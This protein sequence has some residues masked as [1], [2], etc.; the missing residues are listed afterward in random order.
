MKRIYE[1]IIFGFLLFTF[2]NSSQAGINPTFNMTAKNIHRYPGPNGQDS[3]ITFEIYLQQTNQGQPGVYDFEYCCGQFTLRYNKLIH[4]PGGN[5]VFGIIPDSCE[6]P[7]NLRPPSFQVD[8]VNGYLKASGNLPQSLT[9]FFISGTFPGTKILTFKA[10]TNNRSFNMVPLNLQYKLGPS[11]NTFVASFLPYPDSVDSQLF[12][13]QFAVALYDTLVNHYS[14]EDSS[15]GGA[16]SLFIPPEYSSTSM[17]YINFAWQSI[18]AVSYKLQI[19]TDF[20]FNN[21]VFSDSSLQF[22]NTTVSSL[23]P[24]NTY[25]WRVSAKNGSGYFANSYVSSFNVTADQVSL[26]DPAD[27]Q[28][29]VQVPVTFTWHKAGP[30]TSAELAYFEI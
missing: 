13:N 21:I 17:R 18:N 24:G 28:T 26:I 8:S 5:L 3:I 30:I 11:P 6:L 1:F 10:R 29:M 22:A 12:P 25:Y 4:S 23:L 27:N 9:N 15:A 14:V 2:C 16:I 20:G 19:S 7:P